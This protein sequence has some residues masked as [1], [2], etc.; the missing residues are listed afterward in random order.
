MSKYSEFVGYSYVTYIMEPL[1][2]VFKKVANIIA[3]PY[4]TAKRLI[5]GKIDAGKS[6]GYMTWEDYSK[7]VKIIDLHN[8]QQS[9]RKQTALNIKGVGVE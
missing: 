6:R 1:V 3:N 2:L 9:T 5:L 4:N 7:R 8:F